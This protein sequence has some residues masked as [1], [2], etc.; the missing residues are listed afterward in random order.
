MF[1]HVLINLIL[2]SLFFPY[3]CWCFYLFYKYYNKD[4]FIKR[5]PIFTLFTLINFLLWVI[6]VTLVDFWENEE[7]NFQI[8]LIMILTTCSISWT[9]IFIRIWLLHYDIQL[10]QL[11]SDLCCFNLMLDLYIIDCSK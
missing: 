3:I 5:R 8:Y 4:Y 11:Y 7:I 10:N 1:I 6:S 9:T 2:F